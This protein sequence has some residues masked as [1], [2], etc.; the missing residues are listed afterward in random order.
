MPRSIIVRDKYPYEQQVRYE[1]VVGGIEVVRLEIMI[2][3]CNFKL[4]GCDY[5]ES[6]FICFK[7]ILI[8]WRVYGTRGME[9]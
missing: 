4:A 6:T 8:L 3:L 5:Y 9:F 7:P 1:R 2:K